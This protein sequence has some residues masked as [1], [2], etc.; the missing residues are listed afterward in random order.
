MKRLAVLLGAAIAAL[1]F[2]MPAMADDA[3]PATPVGNFSVAKTD[4]MLYVD[5][6]T[7]SRGDVKQK[8][9]CWQTS[10]FQRGNRVVWRMWVVDAAS[11]KPLTA[12]DVKYV[13][14]KVPGSPNLPFSFGKHGSLNISPYFWTAVFAVP[15]D[16]PLG[17]LAYK[18]VV[19]SKDGRFGTFEQ[20]QDGLGL[21]TI[22]S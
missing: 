3:A 21:L 16:Y 2:A 15:A 1:A 6:I 14:I 18:V 20:P 9:S 8:R 4:L 12:D 5:T 19:K 17:T 11:G 13:Y 7:S 22:T 10:I